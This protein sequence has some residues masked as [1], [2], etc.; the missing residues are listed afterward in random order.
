MYDFPGEYFDDEAP[1]LSGRALRAARSVV[2]VANAGGGKFEPRACGAAYTL[3]DLLVADR[4][5]GG[6]RRE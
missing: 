1:A 3:Q 4:A 6:V 2:L 5:Q